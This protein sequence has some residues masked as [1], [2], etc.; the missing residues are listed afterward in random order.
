MR[1]ESTENSAEGEPLVGDGVTPGI[2]RV[3]D[4]VR[5]PRRPFTATVQSYLAHLQA[6]GFTDAP[7]PLGFDDHD[8]EVL[9]FVPGEV[10]REPLPAAVRGPEVLVALAHLIRRLHDASWGWSP[11]ADAVWFSMPGRSGAPQPPIDGPPELVTHRDYCPGNVVFRDGV[12]TA[13]IDF[14]LAAPTT[15]LYDIANAMYWWVPLWDPRDRPAGFRDLDAVERVAVFADAYGMTGDQRSRLI[16]LVRRMVARFHRTA[17]AAAEVDPVF[18]R[19]W[20]EGVNVRMPRAEAWVDSEAPRL[21][22]A[23]ER[24]PSGS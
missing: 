11:P 14:D 7:T 13:L 4:T 22:A 2:V 1:R 24:P 19:L 15:R 3:G 23:V 21:S 12:P 9:S 8:R 5:R 6:S 16:P 10:P 18:R 20:D 17:R